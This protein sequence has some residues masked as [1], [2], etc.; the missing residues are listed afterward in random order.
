[1]RKKSF[2]RGVHPQENKEWTRNVP[3]EVM[4][5]P[6]RVVIPLQQHTGAICEPLVAAGDQ[7]KAG[8]KI[9]ESKSLISAPVHASIT[10]KVIACEP[11]PHPVLPNPVNSIII[12][13]GEGEEEANWASIQSWK[14]LTPDEIK[15]RIR[16]AG[17]VGL[18]GAAFPTHVKLSPPPQK[19]IDT[20]I[21]NGSECEPYLTTDHRL[22]LE[23]PDEILEGV[24]IILHALG[25]RRA[26]IGIELNKLDAIRV[27][28]ERCKSQDT[29]QMEVV[30]LK[31]KYPQGAEKQLIKAILDREVPRGGLPFDVGVVVQNV[32]TA[33]A[34][35]EAV[36]KGKPL[37]ERV[38]TVSGNGIN[39]KKNLKVKIGTLFSDVIEYCGGFRLKENI[40][41]VM[42]GPMMGI[43]QYTAEVPVIK[44]TSGIL[45]LEDF[46]EKERPCIKCGRCVDVC[47]MYLMPYRIAEL[48]QKENFTMSDNYGVR[49]CIECGC[50]AYV[51]PARIPHVHLV[52]YA[53]VTL[54]KAKASK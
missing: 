15:A 42:G 11:H 49:D 28:E 18:G 35:Y 44:G 20:F 45:V 2:R 25:M 30:P 29:F 13:R 27:M 10:G 5:A 7:V 32:G 37:I 39:E 46:D 34:V 6:K 16:E 40:K 1:M 22:M 19:K 14:G 23:N 41:L 8:Q 38:I 51:C 53:K 52:K 33:F 36:V 3:I 4:P 48:I 17:I 31:V 24:R 26:F 43:A 50:C 47:P 21:L 9:G 12:E 54:A